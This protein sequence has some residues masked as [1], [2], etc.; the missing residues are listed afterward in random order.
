VARVKIRVNG[1]ER[2]VPANLTVEALLR[3]LGVETS[4]AAIA[5]ERNR[6]I[7]PKDRRG[8]TAV[9]EG[10]AFEIVTLVGGG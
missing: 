1:T 3:L 6:Q 4:R 10:D 7:V 2:L 5:V 9:A 8:T